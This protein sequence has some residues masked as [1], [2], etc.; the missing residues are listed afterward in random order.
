MVTNNKMVEVQEELCVQETERE[1]RD[2]LR[3]ALS[4]EH[5]RGLQVNIRL[6]TNITV[7]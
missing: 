2:P 3:A 5:W 1:G 4:S 7:F 6:S